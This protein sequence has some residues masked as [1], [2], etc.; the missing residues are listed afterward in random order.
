MLRDAS[1]ALTTSEKL[2][3]GVAFEQQCRLVVHGYCVCCR[4]VGLSIEIVSQG[5][6]SDCTKYD[7][8]EHFEQ[9]KCL[10]IWYLEGIPQYHVPVE[11]TCLSLA[12]KML[13]QLA[14]PFIPLRHIKNGVFG[15]SGHVCCFEQD[16]GGF[17]NSLPRKKM[18]LFYLK[19][20]NLFEQKLDLMLTEL[21]HIKFGKLWLVML[22]LG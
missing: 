13:I 19:F 16:V 9:N 12:E 2:K 5:V 15:L 22:F 18:I 3:I 7:T 6:C 20:L 14:S 4:C 10:P 8:P 21:T 11:L 1:I 17:V